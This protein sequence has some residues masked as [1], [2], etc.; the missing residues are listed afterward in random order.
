[1]SHIVVPSLDGTLPLHSHVLYQMQEGSNDDIR[2]DSSRI[3]P[4]AKC[5]Y[6]FNYQINAFLFRY[7]YSRRYNVG[8][9]I[10]ATEDAQTLTV[11]KFHRLDDLLSASQLRQK[12]CMISA[13]SLVLALKKLLDVPA[14]M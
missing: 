13:E 4:L 3:S 9:I 2:C 7:F 10:R 6:Q 12:A 1:M 14:K 11:R 5:V 8:E